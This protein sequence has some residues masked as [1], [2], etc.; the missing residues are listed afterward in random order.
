MLGSLE[1]VELDF[2]FGSSAVL[3]KVPSNNDLENSMSFKAANGQT[4]KLIYYA[5]TKF[6]TDKRRST[7]NLE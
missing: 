5:R 4:E 3:G 6:L 1:F 2:N 7:N